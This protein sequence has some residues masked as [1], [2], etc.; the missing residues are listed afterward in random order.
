MAFNR[1]SAA[2]SVLISRNFSKI[3]LRA[4]RTLKFSHS[5]GHKRTWRQVRITSA[6]LSI[7]DVRRRTHVGF[8]RPFVSP[9]TNSRSADRVRPGDRSR[10]SGD[11]RQARER[12]GQFL[13]VI[14]PVYEFAFE[15]VDVGLHIE[16]AVTG[17]VEQDRLFLAFLLAAQRLVN[18]ATH[19]VVGLRRRHDALATRE[20]AAGFE[21]GLLVVG[22]RLEQSELLGML[23]Q[24]RH[25]LIAQ[26]AGVEAGRDEGRT[27]RMHLDQR[28]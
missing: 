4:R 15:V 27:E 18:G 25:A 10:S 24:R 13:L 16:M 20:L 22:P 21:A 1:M 7:S 23:L 28:L 6:L 26:A 5:L 12:R 11:A 2:L 19:R 3:F 8:S 9:R 17:K 14:V